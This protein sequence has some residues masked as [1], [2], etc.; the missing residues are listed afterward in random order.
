VLR[1]GRTRGPT[2][3]GQ[4]SNKRRMKN[5]W[6]SGAGAFDARL[7][8]LTVRQSQQVRDL[9]RTALA[10]RG[11]EV[12]VHADHLS[13]A[14]GRQFGL[15]TVASLCHNAP[16]GEAGWPRVV[17]EFLD[18]TLG[19]FPQEPPP[20]T[21]EQLR[22]GTHLRL[23]MAE[24]MPAEWAPSYRYVRQLGGGLI[25]LLVYKEGEFVRWLRDEDVAL[26]GLDELITVGLRNLLA[27][28]PDHVDVLSSEQGPS[29]WLHGSS[30]FVASKLLVLPEILRVLPGAEITPE[31][32]VLVAVPTRHDLIITPVDGG[33]V[34]QMARLMSLVTH[35][36][37]H[38]VR[39]LSPHL[40]W[41]CAGAVHRLTEV[42]RTGTLEPALPQE[43]LAVTEGLWDGSSDAA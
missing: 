9:M 42:D 21:A 40:Y 2:N 28:D 38:G 30:G 26:V 5:T 10:E 36:F 17:G 24:G 3:G 20:L 22:A 32:G 15:H 14:D 18:A 35:E 16:D 33:V 11:I 34:W 13:T 43:F 25:E 29:Y 37:N 1:I 4:M 19:Q 39:P 12:V 23:G 41:W 8:G 6:H 7:S 27:A 31:H